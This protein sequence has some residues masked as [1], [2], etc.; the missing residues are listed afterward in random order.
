MTTPTVAD[1]LGFR[2][3]H[4]GPA[5]HIEIRPLNDQGEQVQRSWTNDP[6]TAA[7][8]AQALDPRLAIY[9]GVCARKQGKGKKHDVTSVPGLWA[10]VDFK[11]FPDGE[12]G[13]W[14]ALA[15]FPLAPTWAIHSGGGLQV[16]WDFAA[17]ITAPT[18][19]PAIEALLARLYRWFGGLDGVQNVDRIFRIPGTLNSKPEYGSP[20]PVT[21]ARHD[22][23][24]LYSLADFERVLPAPPE[25]ARP[26]TAYPRGTRRSGDV[27]TLD[28]LGDMLRHVDPQPGYK[29]WL[30]FLAAVHSAYP[31]PDGEALC[32]AWSGHV[33]KPGEITEKFRSFGNYQGTRGNA[34]IATVIYAA[35]LGGYRPPQAAYHQGPPPDAGGSVAP[36]ATCVAQ[37]RAEN[38]ALREENAR[39]AVGIHHAEDKARR[40]DEEA[41]RAILRATALEE[42]NR[43]LHQGRKHPDQCVT[44][45]AWDM[46]RAL[47]QRRERGQGQVFNG[48]N[49]YPVGGK[50]DAQERSASTYNRAV[51]RIRDAGRVRF[52]KIEKTIKGDDFEGETEITLFHIPDEHFRSD[53]A[54][55][56]YLTPPPPEKKRWGGDRT[57]AVPQSPEHPDAPLVRRR[58]LVETF[59]SLADRATPLAPPKTIHAHE[60]YF[61]SVGEPI[62]YNQAR[63]LM[64]HLGYQPP[65]RKSY[66]PQHRNPTQVASPTLSRDTPTQVA[67]PPGDGATIHH[68]FDAPPPGVC[69]D[70]GAVVAIG[71][72]CEQHFNAHLQRHK[73]TW[74]YAQ[75]GD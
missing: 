47:K 42:E 30:T 16:Y 7:R 63:D 31:G 67:S 18:A 51:G 24:A 19:F 44:G 74:A 59:K 53:A 61:T 13:A 6:A 65:A 21:I 26:Q 25:A 54:L 45:A 71:G 58:E 57:I 3:R 49:Y 36:D 56:A 27:P 39:L 20:R 66:D 23:S 60:H 8:D 29:D 52:E 62:S 9:Y 48:G 11:H 10:D 5:D 69:P 35:K 37:L 55:V 34:M 12:A 17:P 46:A 1:F 22:L 40:A 28:E 38:A 33:S 41:E 43:I 14:A 50:R 4:N 72:H 73:A 2:F 64:E 15:A 75:V 70:C 68:L 32:E